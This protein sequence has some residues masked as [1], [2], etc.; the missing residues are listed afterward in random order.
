MQGKEE[1]HDELSRLKASHNAVSVLKTMLEGENV[2]LRLKQRNVVE[3]Y[4]ARLDCYIRD[5]EKYLNRHDR[6][7]TLKTHLDTMVT[8][9]KRTC[10]E[11]ERELS[12]EL[13]CARSDLRDTLEQ[14]H[15]LEGE[16]REVSN[17][18]LVQSELSRLRGEVRQKEQMVKEGKLLHIDKVRSQDLHFSNMRI[19]LC[20]YWK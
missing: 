17:T 1:A 11:R 19:Y 6:N 18:R 4:R 8:E 2:A 12:E 10:T 9:L 13:S 5:T 14:Y 15:K 7:T 16:Q 3:D 20:I